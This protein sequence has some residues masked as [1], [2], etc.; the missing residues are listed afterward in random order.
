[1]IK[2][3]NQSRSKECMST[4]GHRTLQIAAVSGKQGPVWSWCGE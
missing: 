1:M 3:A 4:Q 2:K